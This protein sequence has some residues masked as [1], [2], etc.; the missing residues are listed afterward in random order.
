MQTHTDPIETRVEEL[1]EHVA[2]LCS[3]PLLL[4]HSSQYPNPLEK[5]KYKCA[6]YE[7]VANNN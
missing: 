1:H 6:D 5:L 3:N 2:N 4:F 7:I